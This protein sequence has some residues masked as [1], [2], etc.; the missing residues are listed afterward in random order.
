M[1][2]LFLL[3]IVFAF[4]LSLYGQRKSDIG[5]ILT[6]SNQGRIGLEFRKPV[7]A[8]D[9]FKIAAFLGYDNFYGNITTG[10]DKF[11]FA[12]DSM[13]V[14]RNYAHQDIQSSLRIGWEK[15]ASK[16]EHLYF[17]GDFLINYLN[18]S[19]SSY[20]A[21]YTKDSLGD[22]SYENFETNPYNLPEAG[23]IIF[24]SIAPGF[25]IHA[26]INYPIEDQFI[27]I[28]SAAYSMYYSI[29]LG[30][31][32]RIDPAGETWN[33]PGNYLNSDLRFNLGIRY[34]LGSG[35]VKGE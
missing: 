8:F 35:T 1:R 17:G 34:I 9:Y 26:G 10:Y 33:T 14:Q 3:S 12:S 16:Y 4:S 20:D 28:V 15:A 31:S 18:T 11:I 27:F 19:R 23:K 13:I 30:E 5:A 21:T 25:Q 22:W 6:S 24:H 2:S 7:K 32:N 29:Y